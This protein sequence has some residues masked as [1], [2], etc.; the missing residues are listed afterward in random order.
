MVGRVHADWGGGCLYAQ[1]VPSFGRLPV[2]VIGHVQQA[3]YHPLESG[4]SHDYCPD[5]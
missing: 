4:R 1:V 2:N 3:L 5:P